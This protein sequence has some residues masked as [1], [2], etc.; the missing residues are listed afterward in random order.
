MVI[1]SSLGAVHNSAVDLAW[2][3]NLLSTIVIFPFVLVVG[4]L[5]SILHML[6]TP[7]ER[8]TFLIGT[9]ITVSHKGAWPMRTS[10]IV[11]RVCLVS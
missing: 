6:V 2:Y 1:K 10:F 3:T 4:E 5:N 7:E 8:I 11:D 9:A